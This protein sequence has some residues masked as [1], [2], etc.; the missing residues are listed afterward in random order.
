MKLTPGLSFIANQLNSLRRCCTLA[1][2]VMIVGAVSYYAYCLRL[3]GLYQNRV[4]CG[5][6]GNCTMIADCLQV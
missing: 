4:V 1:Q 6:H 2:R 5:K 3:A